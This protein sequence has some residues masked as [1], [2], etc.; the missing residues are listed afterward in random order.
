[1]FICAYEVLQ[2]LGH[3]AKMRI[4]ALILQKTSTIMGLQEM[5]HRNYDDLFKNEIYREMCYGLWGMI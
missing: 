3:R 4:I 1:M 2:S 5:F